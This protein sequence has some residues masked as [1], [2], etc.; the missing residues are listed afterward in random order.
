MRI[1]KRDPFTGNLNTE[2]IDMDQEQFDAWQ[3]GA[4]IQNVAP[5]LDTDTREFLIS[6]IPIGKFDEYV[7]AYPAEPENDDDE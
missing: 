2:E 1:T 7:P 4:L 6:G 5:H 3:A